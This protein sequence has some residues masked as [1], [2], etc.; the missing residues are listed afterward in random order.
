MIKKILIL[1][2]LLLLTAY[3]VMAMTYFNRKPA[4]AVCTGV[5]LKINNQIDQA[6]F[7]TAA[8]VKKILQKGRLYPEG[9][10]MEKIQ[11][12]KIEEYLSKSP[13]IENA[14]CYK[15]PTNK[16]CVEITQRIPVLRIM[17]NNGS[18]FYLDSKGNIIPYT[19]GYTAHLPVV[20]GE[21]TTK[22]ARVLLQDISNCIQNDTFWDDQ[23]EQIHVTATH[24]LEI[25][26]RV[27]DH[28]VFL[29]K[30]KDMANKLERL[31][32]FYQKALNTV[33]WNKY[34]RINLEFN[35]Q[36]IC[37]KKEK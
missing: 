1:T 14:E 28:I 34:S 13:F 16:V 12:R 11:C 2:V 33:G 3:L 31:K 25:V 21:V 8:E 35:N 30:P 24:D 7:L 20:T 5:E 29:G 23:I 6:S 15:S 10:K 36:I 17:A 4:E 26:P 19:A 37:T 18:Q 27:G 9:S 22:N 32:T